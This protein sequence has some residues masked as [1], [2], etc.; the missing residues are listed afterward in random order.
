M[1]KY[2]V[3]VDGSPNSKKA[4][5]TASR[6]AAKTGG[7]ITLLCVID[8]ESV[9]M[10][11]QVNVMMAEIMDKTKD[12]YDSMLDSLIEEYRSEKYE[13]RKEIR[14]GN[15]AGEILEESDKGYDMIL[16]GSRGLSLLSRTFLGS[17]SNKVVHHT[18]IPILVVKEYHEND[19]SKILVPIDG[20][21][22]SR[23]ALYVASEIGEYF[24]SE[25]TLINVVN[26]LQI[27]DVRGVDL[28]NVAGYYPKTREISEMLLKDNAKRID[29]YPHKVQLVSKVGN[30][31]EMIMDM[32]ENEDFDLIIIGNRG[33]GTI[34]RTVLGSI[35]NAV[36][37]HSKKSV[38]IIHGN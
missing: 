23:R 5:A 21:T 15:V 19:F 29:S 7:S 27:P 11:S 1:K 17:V 4:M 32:A 37:N 38:L 13:L 31:S 25:L 24:G 10:H 35:S 14:Y 18:K 22:N 3:P 20:S 6:M 33:L 34:Q 36:L 9:V 16:I 30:V 8:T 26:K 28:D 2:L 12:A